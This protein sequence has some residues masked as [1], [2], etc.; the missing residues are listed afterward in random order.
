MQLEENWQRL[1]LPTAF[2]E[3]S[4]ADFSLFSL[5]PQ[6]E[7]RHRDE[8][9]FGATSCTK[10]ASSRPHCGVSTPALGFGQCLGARR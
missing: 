10:V 3:Q 5:L 7:T 6:A 4:A 9:A 1:R 2:P 8:G